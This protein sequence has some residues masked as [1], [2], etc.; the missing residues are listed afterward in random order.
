V[1]GDFNWNQVCHSGLVVGALAIAEREP[2]LARRIVDRAVRYVPKAGAVYAPDGSTPKGRATGPTDDVS[3]DFGGGVTL[4][5]W[6]VVRP[7]ADARLP[8]DDG[9]H[10]AD[11][12]AD[13]AGL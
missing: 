7:G 4:C 10:G 13:G 3:C 8:E 2:E 6:Y 5:F 1:D 9:L 12:R 11:S